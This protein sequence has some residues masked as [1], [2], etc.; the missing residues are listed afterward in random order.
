MTQKLSYSETFFKLSTFYA[1]ISLAKWLLSTA[2]SVGLGVM[3]K[4]VF[5]MEGMDGV[6]YRRKMF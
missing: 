3:E 6:F 1:Y 4:K 5:L 2:W